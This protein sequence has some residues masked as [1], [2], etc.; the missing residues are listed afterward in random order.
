MQ[1]RS[2]SNSDYHPLTEQ[3]LIRA[4]Q[5]THY[6]RLIIVGR[7]PISETSHCNTTYFSFLYEILKYLVINKKNVKKNIAKI[8]SAKSV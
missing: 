2:L 5:I 3:A 8:I 7:G 1:D 4:R 6:F